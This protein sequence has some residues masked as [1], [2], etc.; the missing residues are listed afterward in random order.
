MPLKKLIENIK[1]A[2][3][4]RLKRAAEMG[5]DTEN[6]YL[7]GSP[8]SFEEFKQGES[9]FTQEPRFAEIFADKTSRFHP[10]GA[11]QNIYPVL[12]K[13]GETFDPKNVDNIAQVKMNIIKDYEASLLAKDRAAQ[14]EAERAFRRLQALEKS[15][16][17]DNWMQVESLAKDLRKAGFNSAKI[18]EIG[19]QNVMVLDPSQVRSVF[20]E[21]DP[22]KAASSKLLA[23]ATAAPMININPLDLVGQGFGAYR[24]GQEKAA[25]KISE[26]LTQPFGGPDELQ[27]QGVRM[28]A[29]PLNLVEGPLGIGLNL[30]ELMRK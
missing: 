17:S 24:E 21:F 10:T 1:K 16:A 18:S 8:H 5:F 14:D 9:F 25:D 20:G 13:K 28:V 29:D 15:D 30:L 11:P 22:S 3:P 7:H 26:Q 6:V 2:N 4:E 23:G 12:L 27:K 19:N